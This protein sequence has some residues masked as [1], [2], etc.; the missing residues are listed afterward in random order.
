MKK[1]PV[2]LISVQTKGNRAEQALHDFVEGRIREEGYVF[3]P[4]FKDEFLF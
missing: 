4:V 3:Q 2:T 1:L